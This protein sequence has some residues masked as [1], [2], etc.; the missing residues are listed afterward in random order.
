MG[1]V[2]VGCVGV[3]C[4]N[5]CFFFFFF[6][7]KTACEIRLSV[8]GSEMCIGDRS[9]MC[10]VCVVCVS[11][12]CRVCVVYVSCVCRVCVVYVSCMCRVLVSYTHLTL[13]T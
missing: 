1:V 8:V 4:V 9:C 12:V 13:P 6:K 10:R 5:I 11:C 2:V 3:E 7:Q